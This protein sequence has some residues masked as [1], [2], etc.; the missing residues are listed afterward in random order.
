MR[1]GPIGIESL[2]D[3]HEIAQQFIQ[4]HKD[5]D[6]EAQQ[7]ILRQLI[8]N[9][10]QVYQRKL[11][12]LAELK[13]LKQEARAA[14]STSERVGRLVQAFKFSCNLRGIGYEELDDQETGHEAQRATFELYDQL[15]AVGPDGQSALVRLLDDPSRDV[16]AS[17]AVLL[18]RQ[19][20]ER[21]IPVIEEIRRTA[22]GSDAS[23]SAG[24]A[25][26]QYRWD[27]GQQSQPTP[28]P[29]TS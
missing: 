10:Q 9:E 6:I 2:E 18:L 27:N 29:P 12:L 7:G 8:E 26:N 28:P 13:T 1:G 22:P 25:L 3:L 11:R 5:N 24:F 23:I 4:A 15:K 20:P 17:L 19:M 16:R 21:A 14:T